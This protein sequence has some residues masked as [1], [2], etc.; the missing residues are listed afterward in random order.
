VARMAPSTASIG[1]RIDTRLIVPSDWQNPA[2]SPMG[3]WVNCPGTVARK[4]Q[5]TGFQVT[6]LANGAKSAVALGVLLEIVSGD[7]SGPMLEG[8]TGPGEASSGRGLASF[9]PRHR[10][11]C[12]CAPGSNPGRKPDDRHAAR[13]ALL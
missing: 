8:S 7:N 3:W 11:C 5:N 12:P 4:R 1:I 6:H 9:H 10:R 2:D 13:K